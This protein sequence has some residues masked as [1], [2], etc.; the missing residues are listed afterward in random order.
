MTAT[1]SSVVVARQLLGGV[2]DAWQWDDS[3]TGDVK[4]ALSEACNNVVVHAYGEETPGELH[5][6]LWAGSDW[7]VL[8]VADDGVGLESESRSPNRMGLGL[9]LPLMHELSDALAIRQDGERTTEVVMRFSRNG[10]D[11]GAQV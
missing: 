9:G 6:R 10:V 5:L 3:F 2:S 7:A 4:L 11:G 8:A 1:K